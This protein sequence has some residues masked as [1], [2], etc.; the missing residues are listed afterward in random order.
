MAAEKLTAAD[1][2]LMV[3][4]AA[5]QESRFTD[6][7]TATG[8]SKST[9]HRLLQTLL[10]YGFVTLTADGEYLPGPSALR[11]A[12]TAFESIDIS[13]IALPFMEELSAATGYTIHLGAL[14]GTEAIYI[15]IV[16]GDAPYR[17]PSG[18]GDRLALHS[19][20]I[21]KSLLT[22]FSERALRRY[23]RDPGLSP[24]TPNTHTDAQA[25]RTDLQAI[26]ERGYSYDDEENVPGIRCIGAPIRS[27]TGQITHGLSLTSLAMENS[28]ADLEKLAPQVIA[29]AQ[30]ISTALGA[31]S[32]GTGIASVGTGTV[33]D[34]A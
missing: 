31:P 29:T 30:K 25:L 12:G 33:T 17:I 6:I 34:V 7:V 8:L 28:L 9:V 19:T 15:A 16:N 14:N 22:G 11:M 26:R 20:S 10:N 18:I 32:A 4:I 27:H 2:T 1:K 21:G 24:K 23:L 5:M 13:K 3:L